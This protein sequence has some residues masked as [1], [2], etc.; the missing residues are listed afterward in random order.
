MV[1]GSVAGASLVVGSERAEAAFPGDGSALVGGH[2]G[3]AEVVGRQVTPGFGAGGA[4]DQ[5]L[6]DGAAGEVEDVGGLDG[7]VEVGWRR[8]A[9]RRPEES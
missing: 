8:R 6:G 2:E 3:G 4:V 9:W 1:A 5:E 7:S